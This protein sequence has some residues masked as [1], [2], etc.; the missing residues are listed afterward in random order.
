MRVLKIR[1]YKPDEE[2]KKATATY[3]SGITPEDLSQIIGDWMK[4]PE[5]KSFM[6]INI[7]ERSEG[8]TIVVP[9]PAQYGPSS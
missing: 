9:S 7:V 8:A 1:L 3:V 4:L 5:K 6:T 2:R